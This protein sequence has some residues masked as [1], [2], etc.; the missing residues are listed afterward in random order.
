MSNT[1]I[2]AIADNTTH[3]VLACAGDGHNH[4][5]DQS[6]IHEIDGGTELHLDP[7]HFDEECLQ[8]TDPRSFLS[9]RSAFLEDMAAY[10]M[11]V[12]AS[13][14]TLETFL[15]GMHPGLLSDRSG[16]HIVTRPT[17]LD[18]R[19]KPETGAQSAI[20]R[21]AHARLAAILAIDNGAFRVQYELNSP[22][23]GGLE[24]LERIYAGSELSDLVKD[25]TIPLA[26]PDHICVLLI[27]GELNENWKIHQVCPRAALVPFKPILP[28]SIEISRG[29]TVELPGFV[30]GLER[31]TQNADIFHA[32]L[33]VVRGE[34]VNHWCL[35]Q[36]LLPVAFVEQSEDYFGGDLLRCPSSLKLDYKAEGRSSLLFEALSLKDAKV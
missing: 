33:H 3:A 13:A 2:S 17:S 9:G 34:G 23:G 20:T 31:C 26:D 11:T 29:Q 12:S 7:P 18:E 15:R 8:Q 27:S 25:V 16:L 21:S 32:A 4:N 22:A 19:W 10:E 24:V 36:L 30:R 6:H 35:I 28:Q 14:E 5:N 1:T